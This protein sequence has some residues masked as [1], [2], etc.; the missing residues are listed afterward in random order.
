MGI[1]WITHQGKRILYVDYSDCR[2]T[3]DMLSVLKELEET[4]NSLNER[5]LSLSNYEGQYG[6]NEFMKEAKRVGKESVAAKREKAAA[7]GIS[8]LKKILLN[9]YNAVSKESVKPF[10]TKEEALNYLVE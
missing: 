2:S 7:I 4:A 8:G 1:S 5:V 6:S 10:D 3:D 9:A